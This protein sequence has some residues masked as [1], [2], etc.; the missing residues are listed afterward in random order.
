MPDIDDPAGTSSAI[1]RKLGKN[2]RVGRK[3]GPKA[4]DALIDPRLP[5]AE[6]RRLRRIM[7]NRESARRCR[8][9]RAAQMDALEGEMNTLKQEKRDVEQRLMQL[10]A[11]MQSVL[12][13]NQRLQ[14][15][16]S[17]LLLELQ[18]S[19]TS[20]AL[21]VAELQTMNNAGFDAVVV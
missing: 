15:E 18:T 5:P 3:A 4:Y 1:V 9:R 14:Q 6:I 2:R 16:N 13:D 19:G 20:S 21:E 10:E 8:A 12:A 17:K 7:S 11:Q